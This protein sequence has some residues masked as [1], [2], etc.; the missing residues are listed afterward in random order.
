MADGAT[1]AQTSTRSRRVDPAVIGKKVLAGLAKGRARLVTLN[2][3]RKAQSA[4][5]AV[6]IAY[7]ALA[8]REAGRPKRGMA[9]RLSRKLQGRISER[10]MR[11]YLARL[12]SG[13]DSRVYSR[14]NFTGVHHG[15]INIL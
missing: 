2:Q 3:Q 1:L 8:D 9:G 10:S 14:E 7:L 4:Q 11:K 6:Q 13:A 5:W 12:S 15:E